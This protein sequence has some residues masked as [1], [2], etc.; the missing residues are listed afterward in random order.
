MSLTQPPA[1]LNL[2]APARAHTAPNPHAGAIGNN[3]SRYSFSYPPW[4]LVPP[5]LP[6]FTKPSPQSLQAS[7]S[8]P[9]IIPSSDSVTE[10]SQ[11]I[12]LPI[13]VWFEGLNY[14]A[15]CG[16]TGYNFSNFVEA[17]DKVGIKSLH[18]LFDPHLFTNGLSLEALKGY[19]CGVPVT[20]SCC[21]SHQV[22]MQGI[23]V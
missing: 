20:W 14:G 15:R 9:A 2:D 19:V 17:F 8:F 21:C 11:P 10:D 18:H 1:S 12:Y 6:Q 22:C 23:R 16:S 4:P 7:T 13:S 3:W 5:P